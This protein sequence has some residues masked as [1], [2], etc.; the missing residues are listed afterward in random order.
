MCVHMYVLSFCLMNYGGTVFFLRLPFR[1]CVVGRGV[2]RTGQLGLFAWGVGRGRGGRTKAGQESG[3]RKRRATFVL[4]RNSPFPYDCA[5]FPSFVEKSCFSYYVHYCLCIV[6]MLEVLEE[7]GRWLFQA[8][9]T[10]AKVAFFLPVLL[11]GR[12]IEATALTRNGGFGKI[13]F[14]WKRAA[15]K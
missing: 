11:E 6:H 1:V 14:H 4:V 10:S 5:V 3:W 12:R 7:N 9:P 8:E 13:A 15:G 2:N